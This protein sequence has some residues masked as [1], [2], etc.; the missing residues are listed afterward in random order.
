MTTLEYLRTPETVLP[1]ELAYGALRV[2]ES[3]SA[4][5][6]R[7]VGQLYLTTA[8]FVRERLLGEVML[9]PMDVIL[10]FDRALVVQPDLLYV[11]TGSA[12][13]V[14]DR[15]MGAGSR[16]RSALSTTACRRSGTARWL[17]RQVRCTRML[18]GKSPRPSGGGPDVARWTGHR[19]AKLRCRAAGA[20]QRAS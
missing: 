15:V 3:P 9:A 4:S 18:A 5:H 10:D 1:V 14:N 17:V 13:I 12:E 16:C 11:S 20:V 7:V 19:A 6:Q 2:A 8:L